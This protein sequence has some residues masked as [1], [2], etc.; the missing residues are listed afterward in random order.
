MD[1]PT[2]NRPD[3][4]A[5]KVETAESRKQRYGGLLSPDVAK[6]TN[7]LRDQL[8]DAADKRLRTTG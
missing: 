4:S 7:G 1:K 5:V 2:L 3:T 8:E 6:A